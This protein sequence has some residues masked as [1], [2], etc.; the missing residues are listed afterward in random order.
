MP[1]GGLFIHSFKTP[2][3]ELQGDTSDEKA[4]NDRFVWLLYTC[5]LY[6]IPARAARP[7]PD[8]RRGIYINNMIMNRPAVSSASGILQ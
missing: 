3:L 2:V 6:S 4:S 8:P 1:S 7:L 5:H